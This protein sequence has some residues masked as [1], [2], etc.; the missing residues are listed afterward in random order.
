MRRLFVFLAVPLID[1]VIEPKQ[2]PG[3]V[4]RWSVSPQYPTNINPVLAAGEERTYQ[5]PWTADPVYATSAGVGNGVVV[6]LAAPYVSSEPSIGRRD[7]K[8]NSLRIG[9]KSL[10]FGNGMYPCTEL[11]R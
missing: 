4:Q 8:G 10:D 1:I 6:R 2:G 5:W 3:P 7:E 9:V 11:P